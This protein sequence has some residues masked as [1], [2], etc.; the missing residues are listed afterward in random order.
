[1]S[2]RAKAKRAVAILAAALLGATALSCWATQDIAGRMGQD[3]VLGDPVVAGIY[4]PLGWLSWQQ[5]PWAASV[6]RVFLP[7]RLAL[8]G[9]IFGGGGIVLIVVQRRT[10]RP[11]AHKAAHGTA[12]FA[13]EAEIKQAGLI[14][15]EGLYVGA[16]ADGI[17]RV[18]YLRHDGPEHVS[19]I[20]PTRSGK[21][22][23]LVIPN[24]LSWTGSAVVL[25][26]KGELFQVTAG[27]RKSIGQ[28]VFRWQPGHPD[29]SA[30]FN[31]LAE[32]RLGTG[33]EVA[34]AQNIAVMIIDPDGK[35]FK[36]HWDRSAFGLLTGVV[37]HVMYLA[38]ARGEIA[39]LTD[40]A[41][42][43]SDP[44]RPSDQ[45]YD[46]MATNTHLAGGR[47]HNTIAAAGQI[48]RN[49]PEKERG[50]VLSSVVTYMELFADPIIADNTNHSDFA[51]R[52]L[53]DAE[54]PVSLYIILPGS[55]KVR[56]KPL[57]RLMLTMI[58]RGAI[59]VAITFDRSGQPLPPHKHRSLWMFDEFPG[60][61]RLAVFEDALAKIAGFGV[62]AFLISQDREQLIAAYGQ[63]ETILSNC[64]VQV[65]YAPN[66]WETAQWIS[67]LTG[68]STVSLDLI[69]ESGKRGG[70]LNNVSHSI[71]QIA[72][73]LM[74]PDE[75]MR[76]RGPQKDGSRITSPGQM[77]IFAA[78][79]KIKGRQILYFEDAAFAERAE[80]PPP[81]QSDSL[82][83]FVFSGFEAS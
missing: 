77:L 24:L 62:T 81:A 7:V 63:N 31:F 56:L 58:V 71:G 8:M 53:M 35:G 69:S 48:Q 9:L 37:L 5:Q 72:R 68:E 4:Q 30:A 2:N 23:G 54:R 49:R 15:R 17:G 73:P 64:G 13:S 10:N 18:H 3:P 1:M 40:V 80:I 36:D 33:H 26:E 42:A 59:D 57:A 22:V 52:D 79:L 60:F 16:W 45:L 50:S 47:R 41:T 19:A 12:R 14:G 55:D 70:S 43:L 28:S 83:V 32:V 44:T 29:N 67:R 75:V 65:V 25:D 27:W 76:M 20:A 6:P 11:V 82:P 38:D 74:T 46:D 51:I 21:G 61:G 78:K 34:D 39:S 66:R